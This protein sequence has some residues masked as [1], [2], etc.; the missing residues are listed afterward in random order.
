MD[1]AASVFARETMSHV[2]IAPLTSM[3][4]F[5]ETNRAGHDDFRS[6]VHDSEALMIHNGAGELLWRPL[7]LVP[8]EGKT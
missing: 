1:V 7:A 3:F 5:D 4:F 8:V 6:A 2:G